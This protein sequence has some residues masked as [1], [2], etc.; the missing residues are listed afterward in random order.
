MNLLFIG[1]IVG[2][3]GRRAVKEFLPEIMKEKQVDFCIANAENAAGGSGIT[4]VVAQEL[5][6]MGIDA[7][8]MGNH[9]WAKKEVFS[10]IDSDSKIVRP[11][12]Y[13]NGVPG[14]GSGTICKN[15]K[16][17]GIVNA[18]GRIYMENIN[19]PFEAVERE[20][21]EL[22]KSV[23]III[24][25]FHAEAT[26]EK[27][28]LAWFLDGKVS[29]VIGTHTHVQTA[30]EKILLFGT[31][32]ISD[33]GMTGP[34]E[35]ILGIQRDIIINRFLT[36]LPEK[37]EL[38]HGAIQFSAVYIEIDEVTGKTTKIERILRQTSFL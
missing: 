2:K 26:S 4:H 34:A 28:A 16:K 19:C 32:F 23:K 36:G 7:I 21:Q 38:A 3:P 33:V 30:D 1:D 37:F 25:D 22:K 5:Y 12:N 9:T 35:G 13:S 14:K 29:A 17:I 20:I 27:S 18:L 8:T 11:A 24:V 31:S 6:K 10:F 15:S